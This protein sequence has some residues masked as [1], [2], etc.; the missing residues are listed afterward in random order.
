[1][2][3][4][5]NE[6]KI[7]DPLLKENVTAENITEAAKFMDK[8]YAGIKERDIIIEIGET[9]TTALL[10]RLHKDYL[11]HRIARNKYKTLG[12]TFWHKSENYEYMYKR[13]LEK[14]EE[15]FKK[16]IKGE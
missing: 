3:T 5:K 8:I 2:T 1:M 16:Q 7:N 9:E 4:Y 10:A 15:L 11:C 12:D 14:L 6:V 13:T